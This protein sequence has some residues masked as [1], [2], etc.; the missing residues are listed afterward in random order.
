MSLPHGNRVAIIT[1]SRDNPE[2][3]F[4]TVRSVK[5]QSTPPDQHIVLDSS[6]KAHQHEMRAIAEAG[7]AEYHWVE[8]RGIYPAMHHS[9]SLPKPGS[10]L[11]WLN[12]SDRLAGT[13]SIEL[14]KVAIDASQVKSKGHWVIGQ[15]IRAK[16]MALSLHRIGDTG[17]KFAGLLEKGLTGLPHPST[18]FYSSSL[19]SERT[20]LGPRQIAEDYALGLQFLDQWGPPYVSPAP[21]AVHALNGFSYQRPIRD[22]WEKIKTRRSLA[23][24]WTLI[25]EMRVLLSTLP[26][27]FIERLSGLAVHRIPSNWWD[28]QNWGS[29][30]FCSEP[31]AL[32]WP[33][34]CDA[35]IGSLQDRPK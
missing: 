11:W 4:T 13:N 1:L 25:E 17:E 20:Y 28:R 22:V 21:L 9:L 34:C 8:P 18:L 24:N 31:G 16:G 12:S 10:Y 27:G 2:E 14:A 19:D 30:H 6:K 15:L 3:L 7:G 32:S 35:V 5:L 33:F 29:V 26:L 23:E